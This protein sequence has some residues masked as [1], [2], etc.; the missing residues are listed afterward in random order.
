MKQAMKDLN[1]AKYSAVGENINQCRKKLCELQKQMREPGQV[2]DMVLEENDTKVQ[3]EKWLGV[4][5]SIMKQK[6]RVQ[7]LKLGDANITYFFASTKNIYSQNKIKSLIMRNGEVVQTKQEIEEEV[8]GFYKQLLG[9]T[10]ESLPAINPVVM[11]D[12][13]LVNRQQQL[14]LVKGVYKEEIYQA[15]LGISDN[16]AFGCDGFNALFFKKAWLWLGTG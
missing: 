14:Q 15:L 5:E 7:W 3:L 11:R 16:K 6:S 12:G 9:S 13:P 2:E 10:T 4:E 1:N 8:L